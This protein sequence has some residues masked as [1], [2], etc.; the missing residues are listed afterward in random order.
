MNKKQIILTKEHRGRSTKGTSFAG[1]PEGKQVRSELK[2]NSLDVDSSEYD[3]I[4]PDDT[5]SFNPSFYLGLLYDSIKKLGWL[6][7]SQKYQFDLSNMP[8]ALQ[9]EIK[10]GIE[11]GERRAK[12]ELEG[13]TGIDI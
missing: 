11:D 3:I 10:E 6:K 8:V 9:K 4:I 5:T 2:F 7:F 13:K 12:N 1:R